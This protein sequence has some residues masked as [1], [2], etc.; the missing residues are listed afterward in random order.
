M[1]GLSRGG[2][3]LG[4]AARADSSNVGTN[5]NNGNGSQMNSIN[6]GGEEARGG[7]SSRG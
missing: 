3:V 6:G 7:N 2:G 1:L 4:N 5:A